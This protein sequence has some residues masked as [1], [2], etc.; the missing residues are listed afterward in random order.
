MTY[1]RTFQ[2]PRRSFPRGNS[3]FRGVNDRR[4]QRPQKW[5][6]CNFSFS[7]FVSPD[8]PLDAQNLVTILAQVG[9]RLGDS[10][11]A[12]GRALASAARRLELGGIVWQAEVKTLVFD[13]AQLDNP[14]MGRHIQMLLC[15]DRLDNLDQPVSIV[16]DWSLSQTPVGIVATEDADRQEFLFPDRVLKRYATVH[17]P[18]AVKL[19]LD[20]PQQVQ[21][22][23]ITR[24]S[25]NLRLR[26]FLDDSHCLC[27]H[28]FV[29]NDSFWPSSPDVN[30]VFYVTGSLYYRWV[31]GR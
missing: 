15:F 30:T 28:Q 9:D 18:G 22:V 21:P 13:P 6:F 1:R 20:A 12:Q 24:W 19:G 26:Q 25:G 14:G 5:Q 8:E 11:T 7:N 4:V 27:F 29:K 16:T 17:N 10:T 2:R 31:L 3:R 23:Q